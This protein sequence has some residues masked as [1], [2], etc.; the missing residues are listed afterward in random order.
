[1]Q[2]INKHD[3]LLDSVTNV[4]FY[5]LQGHF[6][7]RLGSGSQ[8]VGTRTNQGLHAEHDCKITYDS[9]EPRHSVAAKT[10]EEMHHLWQRRVI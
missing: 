5:D 8:R 1:M 9:F 10:D 6:Q 2:H 4:P 7:S 3:A